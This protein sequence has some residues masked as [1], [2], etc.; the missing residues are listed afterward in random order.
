M[1][2]VINFTVNINGNATKVSVELNDTVRNLVSSVTA[3]STAFDSLGKY[4]VILR[5][6]SNCG[7]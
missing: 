2:N 1:N 7:R 3:A 5:H 4:V 6:Q